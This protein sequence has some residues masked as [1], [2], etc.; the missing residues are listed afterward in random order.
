LTPH[1]GGKITEKLTKFEEYSFTYEI[2][3]LPSAVTKATN[4]WTLEEVSDSA[5]Q[6]TT[7]MNAEFNWFLVAPHFSVH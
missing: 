4:T 1:T 5:C 6:L 2:L 3:G 7:N